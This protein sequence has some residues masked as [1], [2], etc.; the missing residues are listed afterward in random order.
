MTMNLHCDGCGVKLQT[1]HEDDLG[2]I[3]KSALERDQLLCQRCFQ[4]RHYNKHTT[5]SLT[6]NDFL[7]MISSIYDKSGIVVHLID[8]FDVEG[9]LLK[10]LHRIVGNKKIILVANKIDLLPRSTNHKKL[11]DWLYST[12]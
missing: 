1:K 2:Y 10:N 8:L 12:I 11:I 9:T 7:K 3:P 6:S 4:L 5:V